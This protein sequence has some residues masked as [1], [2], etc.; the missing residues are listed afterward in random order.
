MEKRIKKGFYDFLKLKTYKHRDKLN[1]HFNYRTNHP[2][3]GAID[4]ERCFVGHYLQPWEKKKAVFYSSSEYNG[5]L[6]PFYSSV[7]DIT[8]YNT[9]TV[10]FPPCS[11]NSAWIY[12]GVVPAV[13]LFLS[14]QF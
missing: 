11:V 5:V 6:L 13:R 1:F 2:I 4:E 14:L 12:T 3:T 10:P 9:K 7:A 8:E